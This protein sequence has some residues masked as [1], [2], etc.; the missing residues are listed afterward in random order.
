MPLILE[1]L[2]Y[3]GIGFA[4]GAAYQIGVKKRP[5]PQALHLAAIFGMAF[6]LILFVVLLA[7]DVL[8]F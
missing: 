8:G 4:G 2:T 1:L 6:M 7:G 5:V 3:F